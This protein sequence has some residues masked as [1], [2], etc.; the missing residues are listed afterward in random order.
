M[1]R[2][3][4]TQVALFIDRICDVVAREYEQERDR[5]VRSRS[6]VRQYWIGEL[7]NGQV[8]DLDQVEAALSYP[9]RGSHVAVEIWTDDAV[10]RAESLAAFDAVVAFLS[11]AL[12]P[13]C[14]HLL[15]TTGE[16]DARAWFAL[17][18]AEDVDTD[19]V[20]QWLRDQRV[21]ARVAAGSA[22]PGVDGFRRSTRQAARTKAMMRGNPSRTAV[23]FPAVAAVAMLRDEPEE[24]RDLVRR[25]LGGLADPGERNEGLR[26]TLLVFLELGG[27]HTLASHRLHVH[28]NTVR[29]RVEQALQAVKAEATRLDD[30]VDVMIALRILQWRPGLFGPVDLRTT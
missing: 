5:W 2:T 10:H 11:T 13:R 30:H 3:I 27:D 9:L 19:V 18:S 22:L 8:T 25:A 26:E 23:A 6:G 14:P 29:Y 28:R 16:H 17:P 24:L 4:V 7:L 12:G 20:E 15:V 21:P 1:L